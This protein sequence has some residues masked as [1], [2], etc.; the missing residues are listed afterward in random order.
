MS[1]LLVLLS[2]ICPIL[3]LP[4]IVQE[5]RKKGQVKFC[6]FLFGL[7]MSATLYGYVADQGNDIY[8]HIINLS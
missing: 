3:A 1:L 4:F 8:R 2:C 5:Y 7:A 6:S